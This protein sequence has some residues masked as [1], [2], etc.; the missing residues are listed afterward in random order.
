MAFVR[1]PLLYR[2]LFP[3][4]HWNVK[5]NEKI[6]YLTFDDG[7]IP[8][9]TPWVCEELKKYEAKATFFCIGDNIQNHRDVYDQLLLEGHA[10]GN[11]TYNHMKG[12][13]V[14]TSDYIANTA[15]A[16]RLCKSSLFRPP[17]GKIKFNQAR[18][19]SKTYRLVMWDVLSY[20]FD[21]HTQPE[22]CYRNVIDNAKAGSVIVFHDSLKAEKNLKYALSKTLKYFTEKGYT[23]E[24]LTPELF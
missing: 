17:Y 6:L 2:L 19:L 21:I 10:T 5:T 1:P 15:L 22:Q 7:P 18:L 24:K 20:D 14:S 4:L 9:I 23:F 13:Q 8:E 11:H 12:W 16:A 3:Q